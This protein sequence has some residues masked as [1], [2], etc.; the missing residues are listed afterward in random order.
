MRFA[1]QNLP[2]KN[3]RKPLGPG[4]LHA[5][6]HAWMR[7]GLYL[8]QTCIFIRSLIVWLLLFQALGALFDSFI[9]CFLSQ[10]QTLSGKLRMTPRARK[11]AREQKNYSASIFLGLRTEQIEVLSCFERSD[12]APSFSF[13]DSSCNSSC[14]FC[15]FNRSNFSRSWILEDFVDFFL[16]IGGVVAHESWSADWAAVDGVALSA[17]GSQSVG[18]AIVGKSYTNSGSSGCLTDLF[19]PGS[20]HGG[21][22]FKRGRAYKHK[23]TGEMTQQDSP[24]LSW[25]SLEVWRIAKWDK[26]RTE[27]MEL[28]QTIE[29]NWSCLE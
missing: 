11:S 1:S 28:F 5:W 23:W 3:K 4:Y 6:N 25:S 12:S 9:C 2:I 20:C 19:W 13:C 15:C 18:K 29:D 10:S 21:V 17:F 24:Q 8:F 14:R 26:P 7:V 27:W 16:V 22:Y